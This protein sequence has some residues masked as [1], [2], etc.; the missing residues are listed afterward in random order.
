MD[1]Y[2]NMQPVAV[3]SE[4]YWYMNGLADRFQEYDDKFTKSNM[5][6]TL[7][8][9]SKIKKVPIAAFVGTKDTTCSKAHADKYLPELGVTADITIMQGATHEYYSTPTPPD[10]IDKLVSKL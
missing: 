4:E 3:Q 6:T 7:I 10:F 1:W 5:D 8:D 2:D 9:L